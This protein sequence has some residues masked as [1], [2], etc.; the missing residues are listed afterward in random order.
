MVAGNIRVT[1]RPGYSGT[2]TGMTCVSDY[3]CPNFYPV[4][5]FYRLYSVFL[6]IWFRIETY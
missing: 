1:I 2:V 6:I 4:F 3:F 5:V